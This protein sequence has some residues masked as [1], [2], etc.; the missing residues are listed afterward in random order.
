MNLN[1]LRVFAAIADEGSITAAARRLRVSQPA[2]SKQLG[3]LESALGLVLC[4]RGSRGIALTRAG[5][6]LHRHA[7][8][9]FEAEAQAENALANLRTD[10]RLRLSVAATESLVQWMLP[11][12]LARLTR[13][14]DGVRLEV[15]ALGPDEVA[16]AVRTGEADVGLTEDTDST[17]GMEAVAILD[18]ELVLLVPDEHRLLA[19]TDVGLAALVGEPLVV[20]VA[21]AETRALIDRLFEGMRRPPEIAAELPSVA[22]VG[23]AVGAGLGVGLV[24]ALA[25]ARGWP[26]AVAIS[27][28]GRPARRRIWRLSVGGP[29]AGAPAKFVE[30]LSTRER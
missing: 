2:L 3:E 20:P 5:E 24:P 13:L 1:H 26:G 11:R 22:A 16:E 27:L 10:N 6:L 4:R 12:A 21:G 28:H 29:A 19:Q 25:C 23:E 15:R 14:L 30:A 7:R 8:I 18:D 9:I 17:E